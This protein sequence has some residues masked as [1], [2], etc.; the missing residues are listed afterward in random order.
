M[1]GF[2][3][4]LALPETRNLAQSL[5]LVNR[6]IY[7]PRLVST[8][9]ALKSYTS[10]LL[11]PKTKFK[12]WPNYASRQ[13]NVGERTNEYL[14]AWQVTC[15]LRNYEDGRIET[16]GSGPTIE[17]LYSFCTMGRHMQMELCIW[18]CNL[19]VSYMASSHHI[20]TGHALNK[21]LKDII[22]RFQVLCGRRV[23]CVIS[24]CIPVV[25]HTTEVI[26]LVGIAMV[27]Q[28]KPKHWNA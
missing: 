1:G 2:G 16:P 15:L 18:V 25:P 17:D 22:N 12:L 28:S 9:A 20:P 11:L 5:R 3:K 13:D 26:L 24:V 7:S 23:K 10:T 19:T 4:W 21:I 14:Y 27:F 8:K 6:A